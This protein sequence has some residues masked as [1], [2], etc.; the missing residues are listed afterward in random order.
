MKNQI[1][2]FLAIL[3]TYT[4]S[5]LQGLRES[6]GEVSNAD[7]KPLDSLSE[8]DSIDGRSSG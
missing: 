3:L 7:T 2:L 8:A 4:S 6:S 1:F 5:L